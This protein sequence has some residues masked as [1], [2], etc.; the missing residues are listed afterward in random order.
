MGTGWSGDGGRQ[1][2]W[3]LGAANR[4][5][6]LRGG[7]RNGRRRALLDLAP[8]EPEDG[9]GREE[10]RETALRPDKLTQRGVRGSSTA[11]AWSGADEHSCRYGRRAAQCRA[12][13]ALFLRLNDFNSNSTS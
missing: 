10:K 8:R 12:G 9:D 11:D 4:D 6:V 5:G 13:D 3:A 2:C 1:G 7:R